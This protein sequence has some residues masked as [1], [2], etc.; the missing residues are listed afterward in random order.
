MLDPA[1]DWAY[2]ERLVSSVPVPVV[3]KGVLEPEDAVLAAEHGAAGIVVSNHGGRQLDGAMPTL[4]ALPAIVEAVGDRLEVLL[5]GGIRRG[6]DVATA[7]ALGAQAVLAGPV[8]LWGLAAGGED[9]AREVLELLR[10]ELAVALHLTGCRSV[11]ELSRRARRPRGS[12]VESTLCDRRRPSSPGTTSTCCPPGGLEEKLKLGRPLRVKLGIDVTSPDIHLGRAIPLAADAR[13]P[14]RRP[15][16]SSSSSATTR[17]GSAIPRA[18][19]RSGPILS[20]DEIDANAQHVRRPGDA[21][22]RPGPHRGALQRRVAREALA[23]P[24][25]CG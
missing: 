25:S 1:L 12:S 20:D 4:E 24:M 2:L 11:A 23:S 21:D 7:L 16:R 10:E 22:P 17:R 14:G 15:H 13:V 9:G 18:A 3:V 19:P 6:T 5:D 8:P